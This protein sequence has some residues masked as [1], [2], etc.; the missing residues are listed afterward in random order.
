MRDTVLVGLAVV[1]LFLPAVYGVWRAH[2]RIDTVVREWRRQLDACD[3]GRGIVAA[4]EEA[5]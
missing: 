5:R 1:V 4:V 3:A 2:R